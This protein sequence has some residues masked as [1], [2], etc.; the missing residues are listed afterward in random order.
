M[1]EPTYEP[2][3]YRDQSLKVSHR[4]GIESLPC[5]G[6]FFIGEGDPVLV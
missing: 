1:Y 2:T 4:Y 6:Q 3:V 5:N